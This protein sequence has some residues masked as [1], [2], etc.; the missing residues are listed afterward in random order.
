MKKT[1]TDKLEKL[2]CGSLI[3][4]GKYNDRIYLMKIA[5]D[6]PAELPRLLISLAERHSYSKIFVK[7]PEDKAGNFYRAGFQK[8]AVVP[9]FYN[10]KTA[11]VFLAYY[12]TAERAGE[13]RKEVYARNIILAQNKKKSKSRELDYRNFKLRSCCRNDVDAMA[14]IYKKVFA[15]Y[16]FPI[17]DPAYILES[18]ENDVDYFCAETGDRIAALS[19]AEKDTAA[20]NAE[21]TDFATL[22]EWR[23][24]HLAV[25]LLKLMEREMY[26][27]GI[28]TVYTIAR[29][30]SPGMN[31]TFSRLGYAF[32]GRLKNNTNISGSIESM[33][34][35]YKHL[36]S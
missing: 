8:E 9:A 23:G 12:L 22:P 1:E 20:A 13:T 30:A 18:M 14:E 2:Q 6:A 28:R 10:S 29:A 19:S 15:S 17:H 33:N 4:H 26:R 21:M 27:R 24:R 34:I 16:P 5:P 36:K 32:G 25:H 31:I 11:G 35:W 7:L 3:Q